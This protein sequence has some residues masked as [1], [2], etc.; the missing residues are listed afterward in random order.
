MQTV[1]PVK[2][3]SSRTAGTHDPIQRL[4]FMNA[5]KLYLFKRDHWAWL[6]TL[7]Q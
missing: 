4:E 6:C 7:V 1:Q 5:F 2:V 3:A